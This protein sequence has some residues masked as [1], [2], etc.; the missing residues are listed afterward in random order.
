MMVQAIITIVE[1]RGLDVSELPQL[2]VELCLGQRGVESQESLE[3][4][5]VMS[6][7]PEH[8]RNGPE[9]LLHSLEDRFDLLSSILIGNVTDHRHERSSWSSRLCP[10]TGQRPSVL[11]ENADAPSS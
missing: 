7:D 9:L 2:A 1:L 3:H 6:H 5:R 10:A 11:G 4:L 8:V